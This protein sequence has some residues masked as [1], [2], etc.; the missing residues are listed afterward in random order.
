MFTLSPLPFAREALEPHMSAKTLDFHYGKHHQTYVD[1]L[2]KLV[3]GTE[4]ATLSLTDII[5]K[6]VGNPAQSGIFNNAAQVYNHDFF[7]QSLRPAN[8]VAE[9]TSKLS[10]ALNASFGSRDN[11]IDAFKTAVAGHFG[12]G[13]A[14]LVQDG[15]SA[16]GAGASLKIITTVNADTPAAHGLRPL[17]ALDIWEHSYYLDYQ[18]RRADFADA[19]LRN[20]VNWNFIEKN[21]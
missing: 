10:A 2:N 11:F 7:W 15:V 12:S 14:W 4:L 13:W 1:N 16:A 3:A 20:L 5:L 6:T 21:L 17:W 18:N 9:P 8:V 19:I